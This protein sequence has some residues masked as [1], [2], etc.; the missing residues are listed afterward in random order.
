MTDTPIRGPLQPHE[1]SLMQRLTADEAK[2][3]AQR[4]TGTYRYTGPKFTWMGPAICVWCDHSVSAHE[5]GQCW[6]INGVEAD[7][8]D[9]PCTANLDGAE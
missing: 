6:T 8:S 2:E 4:N 1:P 7:G 3:R 5:R 9:C